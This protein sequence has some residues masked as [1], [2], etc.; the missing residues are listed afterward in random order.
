MSTRSLLLELGFKPVHAQWTDQQPGY[1]YDFGNLVLVASELTSMYLRPYMQFS[2]VWRG[3]NSMG[4]VDFGLLLTVECYEQGL[5]L[6]ADGLGRNFK[7]LIPTDWL[8]QGHQLKDYL[9]GKRRMRLYHKRPQ[10]FVEA[11]WFKVAAKKLISLGTAADEEAIFSVSFRDSVL[12]LD[13]GQDVV[14]MT[15]QGDAW[16]HQYRCRT[17]GLLHISKRT[18]KAGVWL[19]A[20]EDRFHIGRRAL[21]IESVHRCIDDFHQE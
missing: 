10:C 14:V 13:V 5:A 2:G 15:A 1:Q 20:W 17:S 3:R 6:I 16:E 9:P 8:E 11:D 21:K 4:M 19:S 18:P 12:R 7:P